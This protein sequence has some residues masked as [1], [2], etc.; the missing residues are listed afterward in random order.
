MKYLFS[1][2]TLSFIM[3]P[4]LSFSLGLGVVIDKQVGLSLKTNTNR[5][6]AIDLAVGLEEILTIQSHYLIHH[7]RSLYYGLGVRVVTSSDDDLNSD[8]RENGDDDDDELFLYLR[9]PLGIRR[10]LKSFELF[11]EG[12]LLLR[13]MPD[14][15]FDLEA[16]FGARIYF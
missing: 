3:F 14:T 1:I 6:S 8:N 4:E 5:K 16:S 12:A 9:A 13:I 2:L 15:N 11:G 10:V 7:D